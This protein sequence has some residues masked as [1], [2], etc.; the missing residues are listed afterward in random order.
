M[1]EPG[2][3]LVLRGAGLGEIV[4]P[5]VE[6]I[7]RFSRASGPG[8]QGVNTTDSRVELV[9]DPGASVA[10]TAAQRDRLMERLSDRLVA[11]RLR[12]VGSEHRSQNRNRA[13]VRQR[14]RDL[15][16]DALAPAGPARR[17]TRPTRGSQTRRLE[18]KRRRGDLKS[19][20][21]RVPP[22]PD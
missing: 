10:F 21:G 4:I 7:E 22:A 9:F 15:L 18:A 11:G 14:L 1:T 20:R 6:L 17:P 19:N 8:G 2:K 12:L 5:A 16:V 3:D 13:A